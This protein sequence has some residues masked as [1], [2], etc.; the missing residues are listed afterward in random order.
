MLAAGTRRDIYNKKFTLQSVDNSTISLQTDTN[1][2]ASPK[3]MSVHQLWW[4]LYDPNFYAFPTKPAIHNES[5]GTGTNG[6]EIN[7]GDYQAKYPYEYH[8]EYLNGYLQEYQY[9][10]DHGIDH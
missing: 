10:I 8:V 6:L 7:G 1:E 2:I 4:K 9:S 3:G 5:Q